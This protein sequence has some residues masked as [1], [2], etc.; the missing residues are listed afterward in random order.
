MSFIKCLI[1]FRRLITDKYLE[2]KYIDITKIRRPDE[3]SL[4]YLTNYRDNKES[5]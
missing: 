3:I 1:Y 5:K 2:N 4:R